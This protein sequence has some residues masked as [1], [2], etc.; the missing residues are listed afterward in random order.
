M[1]V[2]TFSNSIFVDWNSGNVS[3]VWKYTE[4][5]EFNEISKE[6]IRRSDKYE[7]NKMKSEVIDLPKGWI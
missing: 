6:I 7:R 5:S 1:L 2:L 3:G 4:A